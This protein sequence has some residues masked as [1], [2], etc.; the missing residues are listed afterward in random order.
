MKFRWTLAL[1]IGCLSLAVC[2]TRRATAVEPAREFLQA[3]RE[4]GYYDMALEYL[5]SIE[6]N[7]LVP[8]SFR[9]VVDFEKG[10]TL[11]EASRQQRDTQL[12]EKQLDEAKVMLERFVAARQT[13]PLVISANSQ[14][15]NL[16]VERARMKVEQAKSSNDSA[17]EKALL[18]EAQPM[19][20]SAEKL[21]GDLKEQIKVKLEAIP[22]VIDPKGPGAATMI[23]LR[24]Q[25]RAD[26]LQARLL[27][28]A[29]MEEKADTMVEGSQPYKDQVKKAADLYKEIY[30]AYRTRLAGLYARLYQGRCH[31][32]MEDYKNALGYFT[33]LLEQPDQPEAFRLLKKK[34]LLWAVEIWLD[35]NEPK[36]IEAIK[37]LEPLVETLNQAEQTD[38]EWLKL[39]LALAKAY[40]YGIEALADVK[41]PQPE[42]KLWENKGKNLVR[43][44]MRTPSD[45]QP[46]AQQL[47]AAF[48]VRPI[49][50]SNN[51]PQ[52]FEEAMEAGRES[53]GLMSSAPKQVE[54]LTQQLAAT[55]DAEKKKELQTQLDE[56]K[57][58]AQESP[59]SA[60]KLFHLALDLAEE[61]T[62]IEDINLAQY[63]LTYLYYA[64]GDMWDAAMLGDFV[65][66]RYPESAGAR[67]CAKI[68]LAC[69][70][71]MYGDLEN[72]KQDSTFETQQ[73]IAVCERILLRWPNEPEA[74]DAA[75]TLIALLLKDG[76]V[77]DAVTYIQNVP[78]DAAYR[79]AA[80]LK[81]GQALWAKYLEGMRAARE[82]ED[83][84]EKQA[85][86]AKLEPY[87]KQAEKILA[88]GI[89]RMK[90]TGAVDDTLATSLL[91]LAQIYVDTNQAE[92]AI[93]MCE[94]PKIGVL[95]LVRAKHAST[96]ASGYATEAYTVALRAYVSSLAT[97][98][99]SDKTIEQA[100]GVMTELKAAIGGGADGEARLVGIYMNL[101]GRLK[102]Q[103]AN[104]DPTSKQALSKGFETFLRQLGSESSEL[105]V[106]NMVA[107]SFFSLGE[108]LD[109][110]GGAGASRALPADAKKYYEEAIKMYEKI[111]AKGDADS[112]W[113]PDN[114]RNQVQ[115]RIATAKRALGDFQE[116]L[117]M[118]KAILE[119]NNL[120]L[121]VQV[122]AARTYQEWADQ[123]S[124][125]AGKS[126]LYVRAMQGNYQDTR[127]MVGGKKNPNVNKNTVWGWG[128]LAKETQRYPQFRD[129]FHE[130][131]YNLA[132][133]RLRYALQKS[134]KADRIKYTEMA[135]GDIDMTYNLYPDLGG[136][137]W[138]KKYDALVKEIQKELGES[139]IGLAAFKSADPTP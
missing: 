126:T 36:Y 138:T 124:D 91:S 58:Q 97:S 25:L 11:I 13:H 72:A 127:P 131:R 119:A 21:F 66:E 10:L 3:L 30:E 68:A 95:T 87:K 26:Y 114:I 31:Y 20:T 121:N 42:V 23:A 41:P 34:T 64:R 81:T 130:G 70:L 35:E 44:L 134:E 9:E 65:S 101:A 103:I 136:E 5:D 56:A 82:L 63:F 133:C 7:T 118:Y 110:R 109:T 84:P 115:F 102:E 6:G 48:E 37:R 16:V 135:K 49:D 40:K 80:E 24:D 60:R 67:Q 106:L 43:F 132:L 28:A 137:V 38:I 71:K 69:Y 59:E 105:N 15:G 62:P 33:D 45:F 32:K 52:T 93:E 112:S 92:K 99:D 61:Q 123:R 78:E 86:I 85:A 98:S 100:R 57:Q 117:A 74:N 96:Q 76:R 89:E 111:L 47:A 75:N 125:A 73:T 22:K 2:P 77:D 129:M 19:Y 104:A 39:Q 14:L 113:L 88:D 46:Q 29:V 1:L 17:K 122:E 116:A 8:P 108:A 51:E 18:A 54:T 53:L 94:A 107:E 128:R 55:Q 139:P 83:G 4:A 120:M 90:A 79:G 50:L 27:E 12:R